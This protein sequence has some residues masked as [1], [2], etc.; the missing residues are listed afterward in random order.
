MAHL[1]ELVKTLDPAAGGIDPHNPRARADL[2][3][4]LMTDPTLPASHPRPLRSKRTRRIALTAGLVAAATAAAIVVPTVV[5]KDQAF[6]TWTSDPSAMSAT[7][8]ANASAS[9]RDKTTAQFPDLRKDLSAATT[10]ISERRGSW[11]LVVLAGRGGFSAL[12]IDNPT[13][14][15]SFYSSSGSTPARPTRRELGVLNLGAGDLDGKKISLATGLAGADVTAIS[16]AS[17][18]H[19]KIKATVRGGQFALWFPGKDLENAITTGIR[20]TVTYR[21]GTTKPILLKP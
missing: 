16:Y 20:L 8:S 15:D 17:A 6:A 18:K 7:D 3:R 19:G 5:G 13:Q 12:C 10:S 2:E 9:C 21:D 1:D 11:T 4:I 14:A